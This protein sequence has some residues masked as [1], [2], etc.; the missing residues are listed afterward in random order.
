MLRFS[1]ADFLVVIT[2]LG[3][4]LAFLVADSPGAAWLQT[5]FTMA[6][7]LTAIVAAI[8]YR[9]ESQAFWIGMALFGIAY[10]VVVFSNGLP[11]ARAQIDGPIIQ[12]LP[13]SATLHCNIALIFGLAG[14][15]VG[16]C[17]YLLSQRRRTP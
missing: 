12:S 17:V 13:F 16:R 4:G 3:I 7:L 10:F 8:Y 6:V 9:G 15:I 5:L 2:L 11:A 1:L 14:G